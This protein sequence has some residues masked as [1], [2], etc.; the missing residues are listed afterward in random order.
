MGQSFFQPNRRPPLPQALERVNAAHGRHEVNAKAIGLWVPAAEMQS[1]T[2]QKVLNLGRGNRDAVCSQI[3]QGRQQAG[4]ILRV[5]KQRE[6]CVPAKLGCAV[7]HAG[8][9][10]HEQA[11]D[12]P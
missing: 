1:M 10:A 8:L 2:A 7:Q 12:A 11:A 9:A 5:G 6:V 3:A 4:E